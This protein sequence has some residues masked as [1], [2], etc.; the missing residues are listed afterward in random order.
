M[1]FNALA[2][3]FEL[4]WT[5]QFYPIVVKKSINLLQNGCPK[6]LSF[7]LFLLFMISHLFLLLINGHVLTLKLVFTRVN[8][9]L[10]VCVCNCERARACLCVWYVGVS[11]CVWV[12]INTCVKMSVY[13]CVYAYVKFCSQNDKVI[14]NIFN[15][16]ICCTK[17]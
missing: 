4:V 11:V 15:L 16:D 14:F 7:F 8:V 12:C 5:G 6:P 9:C 1:C 3:L 13:L 10:F 17:A 2:F